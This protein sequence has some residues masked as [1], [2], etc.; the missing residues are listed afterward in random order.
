MLGLYCRV[1]IFDPFPDPDPASFDDVES[2]AL[3]LRLNAEDDPFETSLLFGSESCSLEESGICCLSLV[4][5]V[6][7]EEDRLSFSGDRFAL[8]LIFEVFEA[9]FFD[10]LKK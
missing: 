1:H 9:S 8:P 6:E 7:L 4:D 3:A 5:S 2:L 10:R